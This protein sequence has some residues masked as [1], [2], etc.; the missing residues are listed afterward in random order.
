MAV[1][2]V[3]FK[4]KGLSKEINT[5]DTYGLIL[6]KQEIGLPPVKTKYIDIDG[7]DG[8]LDMTE[9]FDEVYY[10]DRTLTFTFNIVSDIYAWDELRTKIA[11]DLHGRRC[12]IT[13]Y[14]DTSNVFK[15]YPTI[16]DFTFF[17]YGRCM[18][19][20]YQSSRGLGT[21]V[22]KCICEPF[23]YSWPMEYSFTLGTTESTT[24]TETF[25]VTG[26]PTQIKCDA[27]SATPYVIFKID[28]EAEFALS[29][30]SEGY[31]PTLIGPGEHTIQVTGQGSAYISFQERHI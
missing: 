19:D 21:I 2:Y 25:E 28:D 13:V 29:R 16:I 22:I 24:V 15:P 30:G 27:G 9:A 26:K 5:Y 11:E 7:R 23:K 1:P 12:Q 8:S 17:Y 4:I 3:K 10:G 18:I 31:Y 14:S 20:K 6:S